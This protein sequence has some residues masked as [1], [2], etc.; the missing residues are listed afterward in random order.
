[1][2]RLLNYIF[3]MFSFDFCLNFLA[4]SERVVLKM[5]HH[6]CGCVIFPGTFISFFFSLRVLLRSIQAYDCYVFLV[7]CPFDH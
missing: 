3:Q 4:S 1:M 5:S 6:D 2:V 7:G